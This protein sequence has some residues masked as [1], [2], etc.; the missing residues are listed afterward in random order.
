MNM[1]KERKLFSSFL[2]IFLMGSV[3]IDEVLNP[4]VFAI[5]SFKFVNDR[6][7]A[8]SPNKYENLNISTFINIIQISELI[9]QSDSITL[10]SENDIL[11]L[12]IS[13]DGTEFKK[14]LYAVR[15]TSMLLSKGY[16]LV[17]EIQNV[18]P[19]LNIIYSAVGLGVFLILFFSQ[20]SF[21]ITKFSF[22][23]RRKKDA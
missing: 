4:E 2:L 12:L 21:S 5:S 16:I 6:R 10:K 19:N 18:E 20:Y 14:S 22:Y 17:L 23:I 7:I 3:I 8:S 1:Q 11:Y 9:N 13:F 15:G